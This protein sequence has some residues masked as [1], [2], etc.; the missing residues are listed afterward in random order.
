ML[1]MKITR[2]ARN[3]RLY[4][5][6]TSN[7]VLERDISIRPYCLRLWVVEQRVLTGMVRNTPPRERALRTQNDVHSKIARQGA[8][9]YEYTRLA[10]LLL[11]ST[12]SYV[13]AS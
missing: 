7:T 11:A 1:E 2:C 4:V 8:K 6:R 3:G 5:V 9:G 13:R 10:K 12:R